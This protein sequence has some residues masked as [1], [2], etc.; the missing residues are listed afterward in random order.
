MKNRISRKNIY[1][2]ATSRKTQF[3]SFFA[4]MLAPVLLAFL[5]VTIT[6]VYWLLKEDHSF[7]DSTSKPDKVSHSPVNLDPQT[8]TES[9]QQY[10]DLS[11]EKVYWENKLLLCKDDSISLS[12]DLVDSLILLEI[13]GVILRTCKIERYELNW[14]LKYF[15]EHPKFLSWLGTP[16]ILQDDSASITKV[17]VKVIHAPKNPIDAAKLLQKILPKNDPFVEIDL[18]FNRNLRFHIQQ[19][20][21]LD[22]PDHPEKGIYYSDILAGNKFETLRSSVKEYYPSRMYQINVVLSREDARAIYRA[23]PNDA[24]L[25]LRM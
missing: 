20:D 11:I 3:N 18:E 2:Q 19:G 13:Q 5:W 14:S 21:T 1:N 16:F 24:R 23:L 25:A 10:N 6:P 9:R 7:L 17:P 4:V 8:S 22:S 12:I 15:R